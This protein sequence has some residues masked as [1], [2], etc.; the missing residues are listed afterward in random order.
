TVEPFED[1]RRFGTVRSRG[2]GL[3]LASLPPRVTGAM[4]SNAWRWH[5][6]LQRNRRA[7]HCYTWRRDGNGWRI[8]TSAARLLSSS[9]SKSNQSR[10]PSQPKEV[11][12]SR[13]AR[14]RQGFQKSMMK[15]EHLNARQDRPQLPIDWA[16]PGVG[17]HARGG[18]HPVSPEGPH[19][20]KA[21]SSPP[22]AGRLSSHQDCELCVQDP[23][24]LARIFAC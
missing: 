21:G 2:F 9:N 15:H 19:P 1:D 20:R 8:S 24:H 16:P 7:R 5:R 3:C 12:V 23:T 14:H 10:T 22:N 11:P 17:H 4:L 13:P 6:Y 18:R